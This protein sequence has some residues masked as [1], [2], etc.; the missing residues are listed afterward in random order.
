MTSIRAVRRP[1]EL[2]TLLPYLLGYHPTD[3]VMVLALRGQTLGTL[4]RV[5]LECWSGGRTAVIEDG[6]VDLVVR[7]DH[8]AVLLVGYGGDDRGRRTALDQLSELFEG[9][10]VEVVDRIEVVA[11]RWW[12]V[13]CRDVD[14]CPPGGNP[15]LEAAEVPLVA[16]WIVRG[17]SPYRD[18]AALEASV[19]GVAYQGEC[20]PIVSSDRVGRTQGLRAWAE[21][22]GSG[23]A[24]KPVDQLEPVVLGD[25]VRAV[26]VPLWRDQILGWL[27]PGL[28]PAGQGSAPGATGGGV[29]PVDVL[30]ERPGTDEPGLARMRSHLHRIIG[31][32]RLSSGAERAE[33]LAM[34]AACAWFL[35]D[36]TVSRVCAQAS[37]SLVPEHRLASLVTALLD[38]GVGRPRIAA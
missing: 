18:R 14:C 1:A 16:D 13:G 34:A 23:P 26:L 7:D 19:G 32:A 2:I 9:A 31:L 33:V 17:V 27:C 11:Q 21:V 8:D 37:T 36:G 30:G 22:L 35:G 25:A 6:L 20:A 12:S 38:A 24:P 15:V 10:G 5:D 3:S 28:L 29:D 4:Q